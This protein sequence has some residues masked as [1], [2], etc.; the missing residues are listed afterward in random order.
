MV[1]GELNIH[2][3]FRIHQDGVFEDTVDLGMARQLPQLKAVPVQVNRM[4][5]GAA[6]DERQTIT[7]AGLQHRAVC[8]RVGPAVDGP[9]IHGA[10]SGEF[11]FEYQRN[12]HRVRLLRG[13][14]TS[15]SKG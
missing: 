8:I 13:R 15:R 7:L 5:V 3:G 9:T 11:G 12:G 4:I 14:R 10:V 6:I 2:L 1:G